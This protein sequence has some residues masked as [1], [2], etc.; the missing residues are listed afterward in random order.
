MRRYEGGRI[1]VKLQDFSFSLCSN[2]TFVCVVVGGV[3][4]SALVLPP[5]HFSL[6]LSHPPRS[7]PSNQR[8]QLSSKS[9]K[10]Q[11]F[12]TMGLKGMLT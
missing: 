2:S 7:I 1:V 4:V 3:T 12:A 6:S 5:H 11:N 8:M 10:A 9:S